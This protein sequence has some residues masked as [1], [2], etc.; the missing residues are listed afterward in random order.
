MVLARHQYQNDAIKKEEFRSQLWKAI[1][2]LGD[3]VTILKQEPQSLPEG[4]LAVM[5]EQA[6]AQL[7][8]N[9]EMLIETALDM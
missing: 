2:K 1:G 4:Q 5:A 8:D 6:Y 3:A 7:N 9:F